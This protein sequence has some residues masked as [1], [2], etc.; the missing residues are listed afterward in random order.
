MYNGHFFN[1]DGADM[2]IESL[3]NRKQKLLKQYTSKLESMY[4]KEIEKVFKWFVR[5]Y[6]KR[7]LQWVSGMGTDYWVLD[8]E[9]LDCSAVEQ[10]FNHWNSL[11]NRFDCKSKLPSRK[12]KRLI[13]L[14]EFYNSINDMTNIALIW[15]DIGDFHSDNF[16]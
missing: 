1:T 10:D 15:I 4:I 8:G 3:E 6:P 2:N 9:I 12:M 16:K 13:P 11:Q 7:R 5:K 14:W